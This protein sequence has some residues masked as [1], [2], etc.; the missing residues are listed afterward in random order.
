M[1]HTQRLLCGPLP[2]L[3]FKGL[4]TSIQN[5]MRFLFD[6][7]GKSTCQKLSVHT[8]NLPVFTACLSAWNGILYVWLALIFHCKKAMKPRCCD[9]QF[10]LKPCKDYRLIDCQ[11]PSSTKNHIIV[12]GPL[13]SVTWKQR[14]QLLIADT[15]YYTLS[16]QTL[17]N[18]F[19]EILEISR[20]IFVVES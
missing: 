4:T 17:G 7:E 2:Q 12:H 15:I 3:S 19:L 11:E 1:L 10:M 14:E 9:S 16:Q 20:G 18:S 6:T 5:C 8:A 13:A